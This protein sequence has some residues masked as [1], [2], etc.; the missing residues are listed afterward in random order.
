MS[1][2][3]VLLKERDKCSLQIG[4]EGKY[5]QEEGLMVKEKVG[6]SRW[7]FSG[8]RCARHPGVTGCPQLRGLSPHGYV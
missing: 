3:P 1:L 7:G 4:E 6:G 5:G 8:G 2:T